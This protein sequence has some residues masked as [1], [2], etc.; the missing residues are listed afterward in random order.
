[1]SAVNVTIQ[2]TIE[3]VTVAVTKTVETVTI[4]VTAGAD[5]ATGPAGA[6]GAVGPTGAVGP[7]G[8][9]GAVGPT[10]A[11]GADG[12]G[13]GGGKFVDGTNPSDAVYLAGKVGVG[14]ALPVAR[15]HIQGTDA[16]VVVQRVQG[17]A[18]QTANLAEWR[19]A[20]GLLIAAITAKGQLQAYGPTGSTINVAIGKNTLNS[21]TTADSAVA[22]GDSVLESNTTGFGNVGIGRLVLKNCTTGRVNVGIGYTTLRALVGGT[23]NLALGAGTLNHLINGNRNVGYGEAAGQLYNNGTNNTDSN[24]CVLIGGQTSILGGENEIVIGDVAQGNGSNTVTL[25][26]DN[27]VKTVLKGKVQAVSINFSGLPT[28]VTGL[29][30][31]DVWNDNGTLKIV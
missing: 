29:E 13:G 23:G 30:T 14:V 15:Q 3:Q 22:I 21:L 1:M 18:G 8:V 7:A 26:N 20:G 5:G 2:E 17:A 31:G 24:R 12:S 10:G 27:I 28:S 4:E 9:D 25:G 19:N 11:D 6:D 16:A